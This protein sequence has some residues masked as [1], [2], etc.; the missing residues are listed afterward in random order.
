M[1]NQ[2][3]SALLVALALAGS[4]GCGD[5]DGNV[6]VDAGT[7]DGSMMLPDAETPDS[8]MPMPD[9][10]AGACSDARVIAL[11]AG[12][13]QITGDTT[14]ASADRTLSEGCGGEPTGQEL[15][16][17]QVPGSGQVGVRFSLATDPTDFDTTVEVRPG[18]CDDVTEALC[19]DDVSLFE[20][21][22]EGLF[23]AEGGETV[24]VVVTGYDAESF[25]PWAMNVTVV[26]NPE[27]PVLTSGTA[28]RVDETRLDI[29]L[30]G[31]DADGDVTSYLVTFLDEA[32]MAIGIDTDEDPGTPDQTEFNLGFSDDLTG[33]TSFTGRSRLGRLDEITELAAAASVRVR[34]LDTFGLESDA[35]T[36]TIDDVTESALGG[37]CVDGESICADAFVCVDGSC[38]IPAATET[39]CEAATVVTLTAG[40]PSVQSASIEAGDGALAA[41]CGDTVGDEVLYRVTVPE[42]DFDLVVTTVRAANDIASID[43]VVYVQSVCGDPSSEG[44]AGCNDDVDAEAEDFRSTVELLDVAPGTYTVGV[45]SYGGVSEATTIELAITL[46]SVVAVGASCDMTGVANRCDAGSCVAGTCVAD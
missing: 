5:D 24:Y 23:L 25:G 17:F 8:S 27:A 9:V 41:S 12:E 11:T 45:E 39:A 44:E 38:A 14:D 6:E 28:L 42:G 26:P 31:T 3:I 2:R 36:L 20:V 29:A 33:Q 4:V 1:L 13:Q 46:R 34:L 18:G 7:P 32:G 21:R 40:T 37:P 30:V 35:L 43:S 10:P 22:S 19:F 15:L 16:A